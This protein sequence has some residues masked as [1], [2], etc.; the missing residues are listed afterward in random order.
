M[1][2]KTTFDKF[3]MLVAYVAL[4]VILA[5]I[6]RA[7]MQPDKPIDNPINVYYDDRHELP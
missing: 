7:I 5:Y 6:V 1:E 2:T 3:C 4:A